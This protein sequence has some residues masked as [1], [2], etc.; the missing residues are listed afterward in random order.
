MIWDRAIASLSADVSFLVLLF[1]TIALRNC[2]RSE[3]VLRAAHSNDTAV[4]TAQ[5]LESQGMMAL[6]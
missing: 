4:E 6:S 5:L 2:C 1:I 3:Q